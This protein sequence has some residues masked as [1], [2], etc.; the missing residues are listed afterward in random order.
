MASSLIAGAR[1]TD[2][3]AA[4]GYLRGK[5]HIIL[6]ARGYPLCSEENSVLFLYNN[7][8]IDQAWAVSM[9]SCSRFFLYVLGPR[10]RLGP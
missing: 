4:I 7:S 6:P 9:A 2:S 5:D 3:R 8:F 1:Q 10:L